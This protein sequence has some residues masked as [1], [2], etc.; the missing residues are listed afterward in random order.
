MYLQMKVIPHLLFSMSN[1][2]H[3]DSQRRS[4]LALEVTIETRASVLLV[5]TTMLNISRCLY[6]TIHWRRNKWK[7]F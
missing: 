7:T 1:T 3:P 5:V 4:S 2:S 6:V